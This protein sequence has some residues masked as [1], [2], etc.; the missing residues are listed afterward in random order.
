MKRLPAQ[1]YGKTPKDGEVPWSQQ[2]REHYYPLRLWLCG[3][4]SRWPLATHGQ[5]ERHQVWG[6]NI[7]NSPSFQWLKPVKSKRVRKLAG[8]IHSCQPLRAQSRVEQYGEWT[9][10]AKREHTILRETVPDF[11]PSSQTLCLCLS[12]SQS[13]ILL[14]FS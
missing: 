2:Q 5:V 11:R 12:S 9:Q 4:R 8:A 13:M 3:P 10:G 6:I 14:H 7:P 1:D